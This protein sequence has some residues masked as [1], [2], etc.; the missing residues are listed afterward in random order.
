[1]AASLGRYGLAL[2]DAGM[3]RKTRTIS[4]VTLLPLV[5]LIFFSVSGGAY[6]LEPLWASSGPGMVMI[7]LVVTPV[8]YSVPVALFTS[9]LAT[10]IPT[11]GGYYQWVKRAFGSF[12]G[13]QEGMISWVNSWVDM[14]LYPVLFSSYLAEKWAPANQAGTKGAVVLGQFT[15]PRVGTFTI[16]LY[17]V[18]GVVVV[19]FGLTALN[20]IGAKVVGD[21]SVLFSV[22]CLV[23]FALLAIWGIPKLFTHHINPVVPLTPPHTSPWMA[24]AAGLTVVM[25]NYNGFDSVSTVTEEIKNPRKILPKAL[26]IS[27][28]LITLCY[29]IPG[30]AAMAHNNGWQNWQQGAFS[31]V[32]NALAGSWLGWALAIGG[33]ISAAGL[34]NSLLL[35]NSRVPFVLAAD[36]FLPRWFVRVSPRFKTPLI[37]IVVCS[38][39][40]ALMANDAFLNLLVIDTF[41]ANLTIALELFSL[42][43]LRVSE[44]D[45]E[46]P[47]RVPGGW[48]GIIAMSVPL[49]VV[50]GVNAYYAVWQWNSVGTRWLL[51]GAL[52]FCLVSW[53]PANLLRKRYQRRGETGLPEEWVEAA[54]DWLPDLLTGPR[55]D[56]TGR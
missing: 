3:G 16:D 19:V 10:A 28:V 30:L 39:I 52:V 27:L 49:L 48:T 14:A 6:G 44:P 24:F 12:W 13:F 4:K 51:L 33:M 32:G 20:I 50:I 34:Y 18:I 31:A 43:K 1:M 40:Y 45:L 42:V 17:W 29:V 11:E 46:R 38:V 5:A 56:G 37:A 55:G 35:S 8:I 25:W 26:A 21:S 15:I 41:T 54:K 36:G 22:L 47:Y 23:P 53:F 9:E 7:L 2:I